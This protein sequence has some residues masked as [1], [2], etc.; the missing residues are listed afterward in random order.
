MNIDRQVLN[1]VCSNIEGT[2]ETTPRI[3]QKIQVWSRWCKPG[4]ITGKKERSC[5]C[6][7]DTQ[8]AR[9]ELSC[10]YAF[11][12]T[13]Q[14]IYYA[15]FISRISHFTFILLQEKQQTYAAQK[16]KT[17]RKWHKKE[18]NI[19]ENEKS[20]KKTKNQRRKEPVAVLEKHKTSQ[21]VSKSAA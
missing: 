10:N 21:F 20:Y 7:Y 18:M 8:K 11:K 2:R 1:V 12:Y 6:C 19:L 13:R 4:R 15:E 5:C 16:N 17:Q 14:T 9:G 3:K